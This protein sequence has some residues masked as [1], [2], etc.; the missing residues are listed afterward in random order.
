MHENNIIEEMLEYIWIAEEEHGKAERE[1]LYDKFGR[2]TTDN[3]LREMAEKGQ[4]DLNDT[5][6]ILTETGK[7]RAKQI[8]RRHRLAERLL[9]DVLEVS[10]ETFERG[11][12]QFEHFVNE[13]IIASICTLLG[14]PLVCPHGKNIPPGDCCISVRRALKPV[15]CP[16]SKI[17]SGVRVKLVYITTS[18]HTSLDRLSSMGV[19]PGLK[20]T[21]DQR[22]PS[23]VIHF[24]E[25]QLALDRDIAKDIYVRIIHS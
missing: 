8:I 22:Y 18:S 15:V 25:T 19:I 1:F 24:G 9:Y 2:K 10:N 17:K 23:L 12:C 11:A 16:L 3:V 5:D 6:I 4:T 14:H 21:V 7:N 20:L 13:E